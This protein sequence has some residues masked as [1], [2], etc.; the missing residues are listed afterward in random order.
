MNEFFYAWKLSFA[1][2][3]IEL[4]LFMENDEF[5]GTSALFTHQAVQH[6]FHLRASFTNKETH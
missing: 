1:F 5:S 2:V 3:K 4:E 6:Y